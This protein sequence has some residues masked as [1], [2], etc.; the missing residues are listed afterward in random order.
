MNSKVLRGVACIAVAGLVVAASGSTA[1]ATIFYSSTLTGDGDSGISSSKTYTHAANV[2]GPLVTINGVPFE[3]SD[4]SGTNWT[5]ANATSANH[6]IREKTACMRRMYRF[7]TGSR[8]GGSA[9][10]NS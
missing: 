2:R 7:C 3:A 1:L 5:L 6:S 9:G 10:S 4:T 8:W